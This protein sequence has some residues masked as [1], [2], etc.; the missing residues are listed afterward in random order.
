MVMSFRSRRSRWLTFFAL[1]ALVTAWENAHA[2]VEARVDRN[3]VGVDESFTL[4]LEVDGSTDDEPN[5]AGLTDD[6]DIRSRSQSTS[7]QII[8]GRSSRKA[9]WHLTLIPKR[10]GQLHIPAITVGSEQSRPIDLTVTAD[11][12]AQATQPGGDLFIEVSAEPRT[13]YVQQQVVYTVRLF[14]TLD[15]GPGSS[16]SDPQAGS[17]DLVV[18]R[19]GDGSEYQTSRD[20]R[21]YAVVERRYALYPQKSGPF[22]IDPVRFDGSV[23]ERSRGRNNFFM[24]DPFDQN[25]RPRRVHSPALE[26]TVKPVPPGA[27]KGQWLPARNLQLAQHWSPEPPKFV[28]GEPVTRTLALI[29]DGLTAAQLPVMSDTSPDGVKQYPDQPTLTDNRDNNGITGTR[30]EKIALIPTHPG[31]FTLP[32]IEIPWWNTATDRPEV[33]R[34]PAHTIEVLPGAQQAPQPA[35]P[36]PAVIPTPVPVTPVVEPHPTEAAPP[37]PAVSSGWIWLT[38]ALALGWAATA[39]AWWHQHHRRPPSADTTPLAANC[40]QTERRLE[41]SCRANDRQAAKTALLA[42]GQFQWPAHPPASLT[43]LGARVND[44]LGLAIGELDRALYARNGIEAN[45]WRGEGLWQAFKNRV[46]E[47]RVAEEEEKAGGLAALRVGGL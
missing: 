24:L 18:E 14:R 41:Q 6:F 3:P 38:F 22:T 23:V 32:P 27:A 19:L 36:A 16:L 42:W 9:Q 25:T 29:A 30:Q 17:G 8:N 34:L 11:R 15:L 28:A 40:R 10:A 13:V 33:A 45:N 47:G 37:T 20:G 43:A 44:S 12:P 31:R 1:F 39:F 26:L 4:T 46:V 35:A 21:R 2:A 5:L 7:L